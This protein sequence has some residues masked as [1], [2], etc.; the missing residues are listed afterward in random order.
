MRKTKVFGLVI[1]IA[2]IAM[3]SL[4]AQEATQN[5]TSV[6]QEKLSA[7][8]KTDDTR[9]FE[10]WLQRNPTRVNGLFSNGTPLI[11]L[12]I[13]FDAYNCLN[14]ALEAKADPNTVFQLN[15]EKSKRDLFQTIV[16]SLDDSDKIKAYLT[17]LLSYGYDFNKK[18]A[19]T[20]P[21]NKKFQFTDSGYLVSQ[22]QDDRAIQLL[23]WLIEKGLDPTIPFSVYSSSSKLLESQTLVEFLKEQGK[24]DL[25]KAF[26][27]AETQFRRIRDE[28]ENA[29][30]Q[31]VLGTLKNYHSKEEV[32]KNLDLLSNPNSFE[33]QDGYYFSNVLPVKWLSRDRVVC[34]SVDLTLYGN[35]GESNLFVLYIE[36]TSLR[37]SFTTTKITSPDGTSLE[38]GF[39]VIVTPANDQLYDGALPYLKLLSMKPAKLDLSF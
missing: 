28:R 12:T 10:V 6:E 17:T 32:D 31:K 22:N 30:F 24:I 23:P 13:A 16:I 1:L 38:F 2:F 39:D 15:N 20:M 26:S 21:E 14:A 9:S 34:H 36:D 35:R 8:L 4:A 33:E 27:E 19:N 3:N 5:L 18:I 25:A 11:A 29:S 7:Y 37:K